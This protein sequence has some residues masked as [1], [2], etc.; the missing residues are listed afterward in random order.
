MSHFSCKGSN[1]IYVMCDKC[2]KG[3]IVDYDFIYTKKGEFLT[4]K[5]TICKW[6]NSLIFEE[7]FYEA[8]YSYNDKINHTEWYKGN[9]L[10]C[11]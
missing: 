10:R 3:S 8:L 4:Y 5:Y 11:C 2:K 1:V 7:N 9:K 6:C